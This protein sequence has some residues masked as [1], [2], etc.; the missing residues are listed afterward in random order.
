M[1]D[2]WTPSSQSRGRVVPLHLSRAVL[3]VQL[4]T[5]FNPIA[6]FFFSSEYDPGVATWSGPALRIEKK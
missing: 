5:P 6:S 4:C 3:K 2:F 1:H